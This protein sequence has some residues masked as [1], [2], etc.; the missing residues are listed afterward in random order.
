MA[1]RFNMANSH[2]VFKGSS[3]I[4]SS[5]RFELNQEKAYLVHK[6]KPVFVLTASAESIHTLYFFITYLLNEKHISNDVKMYEKLVDLFIFF[7]FQFFSVERSDNLENWEIPKRKHSIK[8]Q[9]TD[10]QPC[11]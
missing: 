3:V 7:P 8:F 1:K 11:A 2:T 9:G 5:I 10:K 4:F 6:F